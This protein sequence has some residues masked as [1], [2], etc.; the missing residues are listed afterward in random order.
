MQGHCGSG[1]AR[2]GLTAFCLTDRIVCIASKPAPTV[3]VVRPGPFP[4]P[5]PE[6]PRANAPICAL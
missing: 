5:A 6:M 3:V 1:L 4:A 2:D